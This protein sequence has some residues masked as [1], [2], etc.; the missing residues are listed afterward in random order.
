MKKGMLTEVLKKSDIPGEVLLDVPYITL[1]GDF[2]LTLEN[3]RGI[4]D[5]ETTGIKIN[6]KSAIIKISGENLSLSNITDEI[7]TVEGT[8][9]KLE[10]L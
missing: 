4:I 5:Y 9:K 7:I 3:H 10:F 6:T 2:S 1:A 8:V